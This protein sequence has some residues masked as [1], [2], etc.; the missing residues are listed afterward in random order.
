MDR[1]RLN[2]SS[3]WESKDVLLSWPDLNF[4][5]V[6]DKGC[7][8]LV[9][10]VCD[11]PL[12]VKGMQS[13]SEANL[14]SS[15]VVRCLYAFCLVYKRRHT[16][17][18]KK[19]GGREKRKIFLYSFHWTE[20]KNDCWDSHKHVSKYVDVYT[21]ITGWKF[22]H[23]HLALF[24]RW[25]FPKRRTQPERIV[26]CSSSNRCVAQTCWSRH[27]IQNQAF[28]LHTCF[29]FVVSLGDR[30]FVYCP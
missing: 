9:W 7:G 4:Q 6:L 12:L 26:N 23:T 21:R 18:L 28:L 30:L 25:A 27:M 19:G 11:S 10:R 2:C 14:L 8:S 20:W 15:A 22:S 13:Y 16:R 29:L 3:L 5:A 24:V 1:G 17:L